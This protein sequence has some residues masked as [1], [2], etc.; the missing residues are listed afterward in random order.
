[1]KYL[2]V[3]LF[4]VPS[5]WGTSFSYPK[6]KIYSS[7]SGNAFA[8]IEPGNLFNQPESSAKKRPPI[9]HV[10]TYNEE[11]NS[12]DLTHSQILQNRVFPYQVLISND[13]R[14]LIT[15]DEYYNTGWNENT[16]VVYDLPRKVVY[17]Y[18]L[19]D[20][21]PNDIYQHFSSQKEQRKSN[22]VKW[23]HDIY[24]DSSND[25]EIELLI[26]Y[27]NKQGRTLEITYSLSLHRFQNEKY[28]N[29]ITFYESVK[30]QIK[31]SGYLRKH[32]ESRSSAGGNLQDFLDNE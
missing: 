18:T 11:R 10:F 25:N 23:N 17:S 6:T 1:M 4:L 31:A 21:V 12:Y 26:N 9:A 19:K 29:Y 3:V 27:K 16:F 7:L 14:Y 20:I 8:R 24:F 28:L 5:V 13:G 30:A 2:L 15:I 22:G 32:N